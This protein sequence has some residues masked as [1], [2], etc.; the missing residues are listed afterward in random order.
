MKAFNE[1][2]NGLGQVDKA[3]EAS[4]REETEILLNIDDILGE[5][6]MIRRVKEDLRLVCM[7]YVDNK[8]DVMPVDRWAERSKSKLEHLEADASRVWK[9]VCWLKLP[10]TIAIANLYTDC[11]TTK[12]TAAR[13]QH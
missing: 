2:K 11:Y 6:A 1:Y 13:G 9:S 10:P 8:S 4:V 7:D 12:P 5:L 3:F